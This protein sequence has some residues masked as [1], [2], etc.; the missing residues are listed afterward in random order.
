MSYEIEHTDDEWRRIL[1]PDAYRILRQA[2]TEPA[3][4]NE[5]WD[6]HDDGL[7][8]CGGCGAPVFDSRD[9]YD[10]GTGWPSFSAALAP[11]VVGTA[12]DNS[13]GQMRTEV[14][15]ARCGSHLGHVFDDG[16]PP[17]QLRYCM[18]SGAMTFE[19]RGK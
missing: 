2:G 10:S 16:P 8:R 14:T 15:C 7:Y 5:F 13:L 12:V 4:G 18:N 19:P 3:F 17:A 11:T 9:K 1:T 6:L